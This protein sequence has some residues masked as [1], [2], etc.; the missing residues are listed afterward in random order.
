MKIANRCFKFSWKL[1]PPDNPDRRNKILF[2]KYQAENFFR[3]AV[4]CYP[5]QVR[6]HRACAAM[7]Q[8]AASLSSRL[9]GLLWIGGFAGFPLPSGPRG[10]TPK[11]N[12][13]S[14][15]LYKNSDYN[16][17]DSYENSDLYSELSF[18]FITFVKKCSCYRGTTNR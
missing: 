16:S 4:S 5:L 3:V 17:E 8:A 13:N 15:I 18:L 2:W 9:R 6:S 7:L 1:K 14:E 11:G 10:E 12:S